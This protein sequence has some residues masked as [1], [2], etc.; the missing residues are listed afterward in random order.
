MGAKIEQSTPIPSTEK[1]PENVED[2]VED[3]GQSAEGVALNELEL[4]SAISEYITNKKIG[5]IIEYSLKNSVQ[6][7]GSMITVELKNPIEVDGIEKIKSD[8]LNF[9]RKRFQNKSIQLQHQVNIEQA[10]ER[11]YTPK[12]KFEA[13]LK[14]NPALG[15]LRDTFGLDTDY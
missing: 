1:E 7:H 11:P 14:V 10:A 3:T 13:M 6:L 5:P 12:E 8:L 9:I 15:K 4:K 2:E